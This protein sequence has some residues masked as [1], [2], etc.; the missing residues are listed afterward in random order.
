M[1]SPFSLRLPTRLWVPVWGY[2]PTR[3]PHF[4]SPPPERINSGCTAFLK[5]LLT[6]AIT[7]SPLSSVARCRPCLLNP[8]TLPAS[9]N[10]LLSALFC[11]CSALPVDIPAT[12]PYPYYNTATFALCPCSGRPLSGAPRAVPQPL[13]RLA[14]PHSAPLPPPSTPCMCQHPHDVYQQQSC[15]YPPDAQ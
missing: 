1:R 12:L 7:L 10:I 8:H 5:R 6:C 15:P 3:R 4:P 11:L 13:K 2:P 14:A 9:I